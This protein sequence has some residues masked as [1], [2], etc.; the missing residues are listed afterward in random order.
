MKQSK[1]QEIV[2]H[3][4]FTKGLQI[5]NFALPFEIHWPLKKYSKF[6]FIHS[7]WRSFLQTLSGFSVL[8]D[9]CAFDCSIKKPCTINFEYS[10]FIISIHS[11]FFSLKF[12][13]SQ[14]YLTVGYG[15][16]KTAGKCKYLITKDHG[17]QR[18]PSKQY[19]AI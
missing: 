17:L 19:W 4:R 11:V 3:N 7:H 1:W 16:K 18:V 15:F 6:S 12:W 2:K 10:I 5:C 8:V 13:N 9:I 14:I